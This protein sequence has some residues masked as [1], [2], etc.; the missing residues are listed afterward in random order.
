M[1]LAFLEMVNF[2]L[3][4]SPK[5]KEVQGK[6]NI[7]GKPYVLVSNH[8]SWIDASM[9]LKAVYPHWVY[10]M[11][12]VENF[13]K[14][15][16]KPFLQVAGMFPVK[17]GLV[18]RTALRRAAEIL[19]QGGNLGMFVGGTRGTKET[20]TQ[21]KPAKR[22]A[23]WIAKRAHVPILPLGIVGARGYIPFADKLSPRQILEDLR[24]IKASPPPPIRV[25][26]GQAIDTQG[27]AD[28]T[29]LTSTISERIGG[30]LKGLRS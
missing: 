18:D 28:L 15:L 3:T 7:P 9:I 2:I 27:D 20:L 14:R 12:K 10:F 5:P 11:V 30:L 8:S 6:E 24:R 4:N 19:N 25:A 21:L 13:E 29:E 26:I 17:R 23:A 1:S 22:G 16:L